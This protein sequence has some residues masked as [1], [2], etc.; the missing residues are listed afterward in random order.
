MKQQRSRRILVLLTLGIVFASASIAA[1]ARATSKM[2]EPCC[3]AVPNTCSSI[4]T[5]APCLEPD[6]CDLAIICCVEVQWIC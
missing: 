4:D 2:P 6:S 5:E 1:A 3:G